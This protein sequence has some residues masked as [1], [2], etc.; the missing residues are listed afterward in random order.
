V[1]APIWAAAWL[2]LSSSG[3]VDASVAYEPADHKLS[4]RLVPARSYPEA[5]IARVLGYAGLLRE[6]AFR[7]L[8]LAQSISQFGTQV[9]QLA[10]PL[11]A[12][13]VLQASPFEVGL[14]GAVEFVPFLLF[15]LPAGVWVDRLPKQRLMVAADLGRMIVLGAIPLAAVTRVIALWQLFIIAFVAGSLTV[16]FD[17]AYQAIVPELVSR[18]RLQEG[19][20]RLEVSR[21]AAYV[22]GPGVGGFIVGILGAPLAIVT[23]A[24]S[25]LVS[26]LFLFG[27]RPTVPTSSLPIG[28]AGPGVTPRRAGV[29]AEIGEGLRFYRRSQLLLASSA[30]IATL[31][32][33]FQVTFSILLVF[34]VREVDLT[35]QA[36]GLAISLGSLGIVAGALTGSAFGKGVGVGPSLIVAAT[37]DGVSMLIVALATKE[38][39]FWL[40]VL[41]GVLQGYGYMLININGLSLRQALTPDHLQGRV[42]AT[43]RWINWSVIP[44]GA[45]LGGA[46]ATVLGL[47]LTV[48]IGAVIVLA[49]VP[50]LVFSPL[51]RLHELPS[52]PN[53]DAA[54]SGPPAEGMIST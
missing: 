19:N 41:S 23:D 38:T 6:P 25:Y 11:V 29:R 28:A 44:P 31:N 45:I 53:V 9:T 49:G 48:A 5:M 30:A 22:L 47:R 39:A 8:W 13:V 3:I 40:L 26:A 42:N 32:F 7:R 10:L 1:V 46:L 24:A 34:L 15:T 17:V 52:Q 20:S 43:G 18:A 54:S 21:S 37:L 12:I 14:L 27:L 16:V 50:W 33:G 36:I 51:R 2:G 4:R 35:P